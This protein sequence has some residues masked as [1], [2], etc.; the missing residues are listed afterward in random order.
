MPPTVPTDHY[1]GPTNQQNKT[2]VLFRY[3]MLMYSKPK[4]C[5]KHSN[6]FKV[7]VP[8]PLLDKLMPKRLTERMATRMHGAHRPYKRDTADQ[9]EKARN[10]TTSFLTATTLIYAIGA[11]ITAAAGT[12]LALQ[13]ILV[14]GF[15]L[16]SFQLQDP[17]GPVLLFLVTT[18]LCQDLGNLRACCLPWMW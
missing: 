12:R 1:F 14:K 4:A 2:K 13:L 18:S 5:L 3:S 9:P 8:A 15:K 6:F 16:Y 11:G 17:V 7:T 10:P